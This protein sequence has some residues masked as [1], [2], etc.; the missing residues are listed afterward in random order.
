MVDG[1]YLRENLFWTMKIGSLCSLKAQL[2]PSSR[3]MVRSRKMRISGTKLSNLAHLYLWKQVTWP[4]DMWLTSLKQ[5]VS[6]K[7]DITQQWE[8]GSMSSVMTLTLTSYLRCRSEWSLLRESL[9]Q[10]LME[11]DSTALSDVHW[12]CMESTKLNEMSS[13]F[14]LKFVLLS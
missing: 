8:Q 6:F 3:K 10:R 4:L 11:L 14:K 13:K 12:L 1:S 9:R 5:A 7:L 2:V